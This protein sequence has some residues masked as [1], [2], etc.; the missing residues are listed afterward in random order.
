MNSVAMNIEVHGSFSVMV[1]FQIYSG[2]WDCWI[3]WQFCFPF[4]RTLHIVFHSGCTNLRSYQQCKRAAFSLHPLQHLLFVDFLIMAI[5][6]GMRWYLIIV[7][8]CISLIISDIE[9]LFMCLKS[10]DITDK[11]PYSQS[12]GFSSNHVWM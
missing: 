3:I 6:A 2:E 4:V 5:L 10:R 8:I 11:G 12:Y 1:F 7:L 9:H